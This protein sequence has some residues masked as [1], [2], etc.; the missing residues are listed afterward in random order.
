MNNE[1]SSD[2]GVFQSMTEW[3]HLD[4]HV[5]QYLIILNTERLLRSRRVCSTIVNYVRR[6]FFFSD[7]KFVLCLQ[8][9][10]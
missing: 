8:K 10:L 7:Q 1:M 9:G 4:L 6:C 3:L 5:V 2:D